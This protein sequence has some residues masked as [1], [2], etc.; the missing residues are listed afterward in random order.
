MARNITRLKY[1]ARV[2]DVKMVIEIIN[3]DEANVSMSKLS[4][5]KTRALRMKILNS[6]QQLVVVDEKDYV[7]TLDV[8]RSN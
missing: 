5:W 2:K 6:K 3:F 8:I 7:K 1:L 4:T